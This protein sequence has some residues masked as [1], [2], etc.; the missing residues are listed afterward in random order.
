MG[1]RLAKV[2]II[3]AAALFRSL[4]LQDFQIS[5]YRYKP[6]VLGWSSSYVMPGQVGI[7]AP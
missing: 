7:V 6:A 1:M 3:R 5:E 2:L 4:G